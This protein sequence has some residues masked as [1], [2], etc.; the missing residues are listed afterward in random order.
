MASASI[1]CVAS[2]K[3]IVLFYAIHENNDN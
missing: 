3:Y 2:N 1:A